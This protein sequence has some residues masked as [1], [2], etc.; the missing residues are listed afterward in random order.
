MVSR[1]HGSASKEAHGS[2]STSLAPIILLCGE[3]VVARAFC[4]DEAPLL[5]DYVTCLV[6]TRARFPVR[7]E[8]L[9]LPLGKLWKL[10]VLTAASATLPKCDMRI[11]SCGNV[12]TGSATEAFSG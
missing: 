6:L 9:H 2:S 12:N 10:T 11:R 3:G 4:V 7:P 8:Q 5:R 1:L